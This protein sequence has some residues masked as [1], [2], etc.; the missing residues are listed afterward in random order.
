M[1]ILFIEHSANYSHYTRS[2]VAALL[3]SRERC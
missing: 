3:R 2:T 1:Q